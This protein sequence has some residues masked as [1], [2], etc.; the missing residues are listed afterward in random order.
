MTLALV[1][2]LA[3][4][5]DP[6]VLVM[7]TDAN[8][9]ILDL[10][11]DIE[12]RLAPGAAWGHI[13]DW[14]AKYVGAVVRI[15]GLIHLA[16]RLHDGWATPINVDTVERAILLGEYFAAHALAAF[17]DKGIA[18]K[19]VLRANAP[20]IPHEKPHVHLSDSAKSRQDRHALNSDGTWKYGGRKLANDE[21]KWLKRH[22][23]TLPK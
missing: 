19:T 13:V 2:T 9:R 7:S 15:A 21:K 5:T 4:W 20:K 6:A 12:P 23:W 17:G 3:D 1:L 10:E 18:P 8:A 22:G 11:C 16:E 14:G